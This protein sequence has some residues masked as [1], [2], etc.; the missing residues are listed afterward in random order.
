MKNLILIAGL[1]LAAQAG[2]AAEA[3]Q[4]DTRTQMCRGSDGQ[5]A[6][7]CVPLWKTAYEVDITTPTPAKARKIIRLPWTIGAFQ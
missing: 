7:P 1:S 6:V 3:D 4:T 5:S 2:F